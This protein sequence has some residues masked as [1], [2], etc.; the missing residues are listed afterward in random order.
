M[1]VF[2]R[3]LSVLTLLAFG[4]AASARSDGPAPGTPQQISALAAQIQS[5]G[6]DVDP[7]EALRAARV[8]YEY[9]YQLAQEYQI[10]DGPLIHNT[11]VNMGTR[12]RG[13]CWHWAQDIEARLKAE[14]FAT[15]ELHRAVANSFNLRLEHSTAVIS[16]KGDDFQQGIVLDPWRKGGVLFWSPTLEDRRYTWMLREDVFK[17]KRAERLRR[18][19]T[20]GNKRSGQLQNGHK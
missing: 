12:P 15:L 5:L 6:R 13:L 11:K 4:H 10:T 20:A 9:T 19:S 8:T 14:N 17:R 18:R 7:E 1:I 2:L 3:L 16:R